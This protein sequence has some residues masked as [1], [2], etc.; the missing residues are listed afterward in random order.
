M[1]IKFNYSDDLRQDKT[2]EI[3][4]IINAVRAVFH[5]NNRFYPQVSLG[6]CLCKL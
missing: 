4:S 3:R 5:E 1:K 2:L 6:E